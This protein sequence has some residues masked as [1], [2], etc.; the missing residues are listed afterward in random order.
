MP[1]LHHAMAGTFAG[2]GQ[3]VELARQ[4]DREIADVDH[5]LHFAEAFLQDLAGFE[6][7]EAAERS[8]L[9]RNSSPNR[10]TSSPRRGA[11]TSRQAL[12]ASTLAAIFFSIDAASS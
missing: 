2:D 5:L 9:A 1:R 8:L 7:D 11:G 6:R 4:T 12:N 10:R 3:A